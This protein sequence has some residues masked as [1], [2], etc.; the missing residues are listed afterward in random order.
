MLNVVEVIF[1]LVM[2][3]NFKLGLKLV[4]LA[5]CFDSGCHLHSG[6]KQP[7]LARLAGEY[8][9]LFKKHE[10]PFRIWWYHC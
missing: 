7:V 9:P 5:H 3:L 10:D 4:A 8:Q 1:T 2:D 6:L